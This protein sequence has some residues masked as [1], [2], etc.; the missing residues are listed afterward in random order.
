MGPNL[1]TFLN[2][3]WGLKEG[4]LGYPFGTVDYGKAPVGDLSMGRLRPEVQTLTFLHTIFDRKDI[5]FVYLL[6][7]SIHKASLEV[8]I[9]L[10]AAN[11]L[12]FK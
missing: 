4:L 10:T 5:P 8:N 7:C 3:Q 12:S 9:P 6:W 11:S 2:L 1:A